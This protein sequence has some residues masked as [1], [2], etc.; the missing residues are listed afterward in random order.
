MA[1]GMKIKIGDTDVKIKASDLSNNVATCSFRVTVL[2]NILFG[3]LFVQREV[4]KKIL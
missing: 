4:Q 2:G 3:R 1:L